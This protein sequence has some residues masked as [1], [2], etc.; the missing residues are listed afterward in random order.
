M[1]ISHNDIA[2]KT[3]KCVIH[4]LVAASSGEFLPGPEFQPAATGVIDQVLFDGRHLVKT[5]HAL[6]KLNGSIML[7]EQQLFA[8]RCVVLSEAGAMFPAR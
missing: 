3:P 7:V 8:L 4:F 1:R 5:D 6:I 2:I